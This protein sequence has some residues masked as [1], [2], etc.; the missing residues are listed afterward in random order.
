MKTL[1]IFAI[2]AISLFAYINANAQFTE[3]VEIINEPEHLVACYGT[4]DDFIG[5]VV[6]PSNDFDIVMY[7]WFKNG[8]EFSMPSTTPGVGFDPLTFDD[9]GLYY[10]ETWLEDGLGNPRSDVVR[11]RTISVQVIAKP[12]LTSQT[13]GVMM[14]ESS[15][16]TIE[17][18]DLDALM[19]A[20][21]AF[22]FTA[23]EGDDAFFYFESNNY[24]NDGDQRT[25]IQWMRVKGTD[26]PEVVMNSDRITGSQSNLLK[27]ANITAA[28]MEFQYYAEVTGLCDGFTTAKMQTVMPAPAIEITAQPENGMGCLDTDVTFTVTAT[29]T[30][31][32]DVANIMYQWFSD[33]VALDD[34]TEGIS[35]ATTNML[36][37]TAA[38]DLIDIYCVVNYNGDVS[39]AKTTSIA[40]L[41]VFPMPAVTTLSEAVT[42][43][44][45]E[46]ITLMVEATDTD[47]YAWYNAS[48][49]STVLGTEAT[50]SV[51]NAEV[52]MS[53]NYYV[54]LTNTCGD[55]KSSDIMV[56]VNDQ[57]IPSSVADASKFNLTNSPNPVQN[58]TKIEFQLEELSNVN[59]FV[60][61]MYGNNV[62]NLLNSSLPMGN[63]FVN[64]NV[65]EYQLSQ[66]VYFYNMLI[67][68]Q[69][70]SKQMVVIK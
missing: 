56:T 47:S 5:G 63:H 50:L 37:V 45:G 7:H 65:N 64:F 39:T 38:T 33:G 35:G 44:K 61:D 40:T 27:I 1:K 26:T 32:G 12:K 20:G 13:G 10:F 41:T 53:G 58:A 4:D 59:L 55:V 28:D 2:A 60:T 22:N 9:A 43:T 36:T 68:G 15:E 62:A 8:E 67:N 48:A 19:K 25:D 46:T 29:A 14:M 49:T 21:G 30:N 42:V 70:I 31:N 17:G 54:V 34:A 51:E 57:A 6:K 24:I 18:T 69:L 23:T 16:V 3:T 11:S 52:A 66:G